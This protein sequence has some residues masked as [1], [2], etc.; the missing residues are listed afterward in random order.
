MSDQG[1]DPA[2]NSFAERTDTDNAFNTTALHE[3]LEANGQNPCRVAGSSGMMCSEH[4]G[5]VEVDIE[6]M[7][8]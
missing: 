3:A 6:Q 2:P 1:W 7:K 8:D 5:T 4:C